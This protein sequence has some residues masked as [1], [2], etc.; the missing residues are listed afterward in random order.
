MQQRIFKIQS[1]TNK[2]QVWKSPKRWEIQ[3]WLNYMCFFQISKAFFWRYSSKTKISKIRF[4][5]DLF[6]ELIE[7]KWH[8]TLSLFLLYK[9]S[10]SYLKFDVLVFSYTPFK[11]SKI[12]STK[13]EKQ[14]QN[15][16]VWDFDVS[17]FGSHPQGKN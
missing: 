7:N 14:N 16:H 4:F 6:N 11:C 13:F 8:F 9:V 12:F 15:F 3:S 5:S 10:K 2:K 17:V 1:V